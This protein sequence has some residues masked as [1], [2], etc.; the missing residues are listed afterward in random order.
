MRWKHA[1]PLATLAL[2]TLPGAAFSQSSQKAMTIIAP[3]PPG[4]SADGIARIIATE[5]SARLGRQTIVDNRPGVG[6]TL[7]LTIAAKAPPDGDTLTVGATGGL[8]ISPHIPSS[9]QFDPLKELAPI[10]KLIDIPIVLVTNAKT[11]AKTV[12]ELIEKS[13]NTPGGVSFG[14]TG[15]NSSQHLAVELLKNMTGAN[16]VHVPYRGSAPAVTAVLGDQIP[17]ASV[18]LTSAYEHTKAGTLTA[19]GVTSAHRAKIAPEIPTVAEGGVPGFDGS[20]G[21]IGLFAP[22]GTP[23]DKIK[24]LSRDVAAIIAR[25]DV[26]DRIKLLAVEPAYSDDVT[27]KAFLAVESAKWK[28]VLKS[29]AAAQ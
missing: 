20:A 7:G 15:V 14:T 9:T 3:F 4:G 22:A 26:Q 19:L 29:R 17:M 25:P 21:Y 18:D 12:K 23:P 27:F 28:D 8:V 1:L 6:G 10:A 11:G 2:L 13:K 24:Q 5:L 16:L